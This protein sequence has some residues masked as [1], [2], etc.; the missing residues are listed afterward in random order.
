MKWQWL[1]ALGALW[2]CSS[3]AG[4][5]AP[6]CIPVLRASEAPKVDGVAAEP[7]WAATETVT[8]ADG[9]LSVRAFYTADGMAL[10]VRCL[11][12]PETI[13]TKAAQR[14]AD[15][16]DDSSV[17]VLLM[18][19]YRTHG[20]LEQPGPFQYYRLGVNA[21]GVVFDA[22][23]E[24]DGA[25]YDGEWQAAARRERDGWSAEYFIPFWG[26]VDWQQRTPPLC[27]SWRWQVLLRQP[28]RPVTALF[29]S[30]APGDS[31]Q[32]GE[33]VFFG[34]ALPAEPLRTLDAYRVFDPVRWEMEVQSAAIP[35][36][37]DVTK[38]LEEYQVFQ[39]RVAAAAPEDYSLH[40]DEWLA[41]AAGFPVRLRQLYSELLTETVRLASMDFAVV[42]HPALR[43]DKIATPDTLPDLRLLGEGVNFTVAPNE[44]E[45]ASLLV[46]S[47]R[48]LT[49]VTV[50]VSDL[51]N[52]GKVIPADKLEVF[53]V[54]CWYQ[55]SVTDIVNTGKVLTP[56]LL[57]RNPELVQVDLVNEVNL[58]PFG[59]RNF[60][61]YPED[62]A[63]LLP[64]PELPARQTQQI[65][66]TTTPLAGYEPGIYHG[67]VTVRAAGGAVEVPLTLELLEFELAASPIVHAMYT[68]S[69]WGPATEE[70]ALAEMRNL[71]EHGCLTV[72]LADYAKN[73]PRVVAWMRETGLNTREL[74]LQNVCGW[75]LPE[76]SDA[77]YIE[78]KAR[79]ARELLTPLGVEDIYLYM[80]DEA[81][82]D[83]LRDS[84]R[85]AR[86]ASK[87]GVK[88][89]SA[90]YQ[91]YFDI[92]G[93]ALDLVVLAHAPAPRELVDKIHGAGKR[94]FC[95]ANP[96]GGVERPEIY[97]R[98]FGLLLWQAHYDGGMTFA[99][100]W[101]F[102]KAP[103]YDPWDDFDHPVFRDHNMV[104]VTQGAP[105]DTIQWEGWREGYDDCRYLGTLLAA[106]GEAR[107]AGKP[108]AAARAEAWVAGLRDD[109][110]RLADLDALR[111]E[112]I[113]QIRAL[114]E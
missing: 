109:R 54:K 5:L 99:W 90:A 16:A 73:L 101:P 10:F 65:W 20:V 37:A 110:T 106:I 50:E 78:E 82:G 102:G 9:K 71:V 7:A 112:L 60:R 42:P 35:P 13:R 43:D 72:G 31:A 23:G 68:D 36:S 6:D 74:Y 46:W 96:Q 64:L 51:A 76:G 69:N 25:S 19:D 89:W 75:E 57:L 22:V 70:Q 114:K 58:K 8:S 21:A 17:E 87:A 41:Q 39:R 105:V 48:A 92:A 24:R 100:N 86:I 12:D 18:P 3:V 62:A 107:A 108:E 93:D 66:L 88:S 53:W 91:D 97:R 40:R 77:A 45:A 38:L 83:R 113:A 49:G 27:S 80:V 34:N 4:G 26:T 98:N 2:A 104:Y 103:Y 29:A 14:D 111:R 63:E 81:R 30:D 44:Y 15:L 56:E 95:Y 11:A 32:F 47:D 55:G 67:T 52:G 59:N 94:V 1:A 61:D 84:A 85:M 28:G 33:M 79:M